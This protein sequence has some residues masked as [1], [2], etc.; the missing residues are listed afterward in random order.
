MERKQTDW[1]GQ[2]L[3]AGIDVHRKT[4]AVTVRTGDLVIK[5]FTTEASNEVL[6]KSFQ[7]LWPGAKINAVYEAGCFGYHLAEF[8]NRN[9]ISTII[10]APHTIPVAPGLFVKTDKLDSKKLAFELAKGA[11]TGIYCPSRAE[12]YDRGLLRKRRQLI[13]RKVQIQ[14]QIKADIT[15]YGIKSIANSY[16][17]WSKASIK[18]LR[19]PGFNNPLYSK[20]FGFLITEYEELIGLIKE[21]DLL[22]SE[23]SQTEKYK[24]MIELLKSIPGI[25][26]VAALNIMLEIGDIRR[27]ASA[28]KFASYIGLTPSE[29]SS[30]ESRHIGSL[31]GMGQA[32]L[33]ATFVESAWLA[34]KQDPALLR[35]YQKLKLRKR[36]TQAIVAV[37]RSL[38][39][40]T[41]RVML[42][43]EPY[44]LGVVS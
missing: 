19:N 25:G 10:V 4:W 28:E 35:K 3:Y 9:G 7:R 30:G 44:E 20:A 29:Y 33:R 40:R 18:E 5:T 41:R 1:T 34:I 38:A 23:L 12:L 8:L 17:Y 24:K 32:V 14:N 36:P 11:L 31:T 37:A 27:F 6:L 21:L 15:F 42:T 13:K 2:I 22:L 26:H 16:R 39:N 43:E